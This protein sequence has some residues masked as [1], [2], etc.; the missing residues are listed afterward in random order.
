LTDQPASSSRTH[1]APGIEALVPWADFVNHSP[2]CRSHLR[3]SRAVSEAG[4]GFPFM[5][6]GATS[7]GAT[8]VLEA[9]RPYYP[10]QQVYTSYGEK[11]SG[12]LLLSYGFVP[13]PG[14]NPYDAFTL[15]V[16]VCC[17]LSASWC[18]GKFSAT[19]VDLQHLPYT[20]CY[21]RNNNVAQES[22]A[23]G[24]PVCA[25]CCGATLRDV[26]M[27]QHWCAAPR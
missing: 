10:G 22:Y 23:I 13:L 11:P 24:L 17:G 16:T 2:G 8:I 9:D 26:N 20:E 19:D 4:F 5:S 7:H 14:T 27:V 12:E 25:C 6:G 15:H 21:S 18:A 1:D 3:L